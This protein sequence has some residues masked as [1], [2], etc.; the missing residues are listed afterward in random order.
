M[1]ELVADPRSSVGVRFGRSELASWGTGQ[2]GSSGLALDGET[3]NMSPTGP[4]RPSITSGH[5][6]RAH[7]AGIP[8]GTV[9]SVHYSG[10]LLTKSVLVTPLAQLSGLGYVTV[11]QWFPAGDATGLGTAG[12]AA[13][14][15]GD[16]PGRRPRRHRRRGA[17]PDAFLVLAIVGGLVAGPQRGA[18]IAFLAGLI[19]GLFVV[20]PFGLTSLCFVLVAFTAGLASR[21]SAG[22]APYSFRFGTALIGGVAA[23]L[24]TPLRPVSSVSRTSPVTNWPQSP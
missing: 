19:A 5:H 4:G 13:L 11:L 6:R 18:V 7:P 3:A 15:N 9:T 2:G 22:R 21:L 16:P 20:T 24:R 12:R 23:T 14:G 8:V 10:G 1:V 17:H